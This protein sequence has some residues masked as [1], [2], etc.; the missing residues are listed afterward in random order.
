MYKCIRVHGHRG[1]QFVHSRGD[2][3]HR[4][5]T[6]LH[7][8]CRSILSSHHVLHKRVVNEH[9]DFNG[10]CTVAHRLSRILPQGLCRTT[11]HVVRSALNNSDFNVC[12]VSGNNHFT[13]LI[14][15][16]PRT[17]SLFDGSILLRGCTGVIA[18]LSRNK[19]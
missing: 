2:L 15:T 12:Q 16:D 5:L 7:S 8:L 4:Q 19:L 10:V 17:R 6:F 13:R 1:L 11:V 9:S 3:L 18:T 14:T